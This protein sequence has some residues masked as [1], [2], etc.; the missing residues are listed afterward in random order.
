[1]KPAIDVTPPKTADEAAP[2]A[3]VQWPFAFRPTLGQWAL[4][5]FAIACLFGT[6]VIVWPEA[7]G[8]SGLVFLIGITLCGAALMFAMT[9]GRLV[10]AEAPARL[11]GAAL[12]VDMRPCCITTP[13]GSVGYVNPAWRKMFGTSSAGG[14][15]LPVAGVSADPETAQRLYKLVRAASLKEAHEEELKLKN[16]AG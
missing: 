8:I 3:R 11:F 14:D 16:L 5:L 9:S 7:A 10:P 2:A 1:M 4:V 15:I 13:D 6:A 12:D